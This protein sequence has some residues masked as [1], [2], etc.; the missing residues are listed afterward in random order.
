MMAAFADTAF[1]TASF[2]TTAWSFA[3]PTISPDRPDG[4]YRRAAAAIL[5]SR[6]TGPHN[7][8]FVRIARRR[9]RRQ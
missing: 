3:A 5:T 4:L 1:A 2:S 7:A 6:T 9:E 8:V